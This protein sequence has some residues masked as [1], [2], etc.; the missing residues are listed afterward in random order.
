[1]KFKKDSFVVKTAFKDLTPPDE[2]S[3]CVLFRKFICGIMTGVI[4]NAIIIISY[5]I[6]TPI[7]FLFGYIPARFDKNN[8]DLFREIYFED[9]PGTL[10]RF[11]PFWASFI[12]FM[13][14]WSYGIYQKY[15][16][17]E[18]GIEVVSTISG[19][20][21]FILQLSVSI[22]VG[23]IFSFLFTFIVVRA[24]NV[25]HNSSTVDLFKAK[26][27]ATK[28]KICPIVSIVD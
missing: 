5:I 11:T 8:G 14:M 24:R 9:I 20:P 1:M 18:I 21:M 27:S 15:F 3:L 28:E 10:Y 7:A 22:L 25:W 19:W 2:I 13:I 6:G 12:I 16:F 26:M 23:T 17:S 4:A